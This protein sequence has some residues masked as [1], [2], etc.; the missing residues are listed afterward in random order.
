MMTEDTE[1][2]SEKYDEYPDL[3]ELD[4]ELEDFE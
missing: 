4:E 1:P 3:E 2:P